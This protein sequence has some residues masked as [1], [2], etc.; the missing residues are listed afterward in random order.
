[1]RINVAEP[2]TSGYQLSP[3]LTDGKLP[4]DFQPDTII[5][6]NQDQD[7]EFERQL[8]KKSAERSIPVH[9]RFEESAEGF[10]LHIHDDAGIS[11]SA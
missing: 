2:T 9:L 6:R 1:M 8:E 5:Y 10:I 11:A 4:A 7:Q 3:T